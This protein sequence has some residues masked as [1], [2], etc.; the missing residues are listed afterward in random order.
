MY[1]HGPVSMS[2]YFAFALTAAVLIIVT[3]VGCQKEEQCE[4][5]V[6]GSPVLL[7]DDPETSPIASTEFGRSSWPSVEGPLQSIE[8]TYFY[9]YTRDYQGNAAQERTSPIRIFSSVRRGTQFR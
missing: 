5:I 8:E 6:L 7:F 1:R 9:Q 3:M 4:P 2:L